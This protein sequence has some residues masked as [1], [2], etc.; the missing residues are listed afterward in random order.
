MVQCLSV[1]LFFTSRQN[2]LTYLM[3]LIFGIEDTLDLSY[4]HC[5]LKEFR[6]F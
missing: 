5:I 1:C 4:I 3:Y 6:Y 2:D